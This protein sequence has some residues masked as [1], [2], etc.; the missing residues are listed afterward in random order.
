[1]RSRIATPSGILPDQTFP[2]FLQLNSAAFFAPRGTRNLLLREC[3]EVVRVCCREE[4]GAF[5]YRDRRILA[6]INMAHALQKDRG[7]PRNHKPGP[8]GAEEL[9]KRFVT[10]SFCVLA[11]FALPALADE[12]KPDATTTAPTEGTPAP[13]GEAEPDCK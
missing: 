7:L 11:F 3:A 12:A 9:M 4:P 5:V 2:C 13:T 6:S 10:L 8:P 1:M